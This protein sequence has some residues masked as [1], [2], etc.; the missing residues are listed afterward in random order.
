LVKTVAEKIKRIF[1]KYILE[2]ILIFAKEYISYF[3]KLIVFIYF[4]FYFNYQKLKIQCDVFTI[5]FYIEFACKLQFKRIMFSMTHK[6]CHTY[7]LD[8]ELKGACKLKVR[9]WKQAEY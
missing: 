9:G 2:Y 7:W 4:T 1:F 3:V 8:Q 5:S 6:S